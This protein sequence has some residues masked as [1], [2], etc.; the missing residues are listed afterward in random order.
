[1]SFLQ[2]PSQPPRMNLFRN[3]NDS[4]PCS[5]VAGAPIGMVLPAS[6][7]IVWSAAL[8]CGRRVGIPSGCAQPFVA[9]PVVSL[10]LNHRLMAVMPPAFEER[11]GPVGLVFVLAR[12][13]WVG[14][15]RL[16]SSS[17]EGFL[18]ER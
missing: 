5:V 2:D 18:I 9:C 17:E 7:G 11:V 1:M 4:P 14:L 15:W 10:S 16:A 8:L 12:W 3:P 13:V 6:G